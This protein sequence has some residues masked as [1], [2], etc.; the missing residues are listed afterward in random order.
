MRGAIS[1]LVASLNDPYTFFAGPETTEVDEDNLAG[2]FG[3]IGA[4]IGIDEAGHYVILR[5]YPGNPA[6]AAGVRVG[7]IILAVDGVEVSPQTTSMYDLLAA[8]RGEIGDP[9]ILRLGRGPE[10]FELEIVRAEVLIP[11][12]FWRVLEED[13]RIGYIQITRFTDRTPEEVRQGIGELLDQDVKAFILDL[14]DNGGGLVESAVQVA[15]EFLDGGPILYEVR[16]GQDEKAYNASRGGLAVEQP[17]VVL[18]NGGSASASEILAGAFQDRGR[19]LLVGE[20]TFGKGSVQLIFSLSDGSS[21]HVTAA[22]WYT[23]DHH[24]IEQQGL[25]PD[26]TVTPEAGRDAALAAALEVLG[27]RLPVA[28]MQNADDE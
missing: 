24:R 11:S 21:L 5:V 27:S 2:R 4:E 14:R 12:T 8:L 17:L 16:R 15:S 9:V 6:E 25:T 28:E 20:P 13:S 1:G 26:L 19:A 10:V 23:P 18:V 7:D 22:E 3:G